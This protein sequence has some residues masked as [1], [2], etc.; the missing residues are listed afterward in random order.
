MNAEKAVSGA[1]GIKNAL[2]G[3]LNFNTKLSLTVAD[4]NEMMHSMKGALN[5]SVKDGAFGTIGR[6][7]NL[8]QADN[9]VNNTL[10]KSTVTAITKAIGIAD[11]AKFSYINGELAFSDGWA[12]LKPIKSSGPLLAYYIKGK[13][14]LINANTIL[15]ILGRLDATVVAKL[16]PLGDLSASKL[17]GYIPTFG[18][19]TVSAIN[20]LTAS[21]KNENIDAI[22]VLSSGS[23]SYKDFKVVHNGVL[24]KPKS[25]KSFK[26]LTDVDTSAIETKT[27]KETVENI[28][29][30]VNEDVTNTIQA[31]SD[32]VQNSKEQWNITKDQLKNSAE[33]LKNLFN[34][35]KEEKP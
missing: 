21:P 23:T 31:V 18:T 22:P 10:L 2:S 27:I 26:W 5:F 7:E 4:Y 35:K 14:N 25:I 11:T 15:T 1:A 29:Q 16:G 19:N 20:A 3:T 6:I 9:I 17:L 28:K 24:G 12:E 13:Y 34:F 30:S 33:E 32:A 8:L